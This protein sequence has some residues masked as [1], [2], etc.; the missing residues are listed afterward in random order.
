[1]SRRTEIGLFV[2]LLAVLAAAVYWNFR[3]ASSVGA[4]APMAIS[5]EPLR[6]K[7]PSLHLDRLEQLRQLSYSGSH[8]NIFSA[9]PPPLPP[10]A[11]AKK[12]GGAAGGGAETAGPPVPPALQVPLKFYGMAVDPK[13][14]KKLA[15]FTSG[16]DVYIA[17]QGQTLLGR[18]RLLSIGNDTVE[19][20]ESTSG[21]RATLTMTP[22]VTP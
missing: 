22:P 17:G 9:T 2:V 6:V 13:T 16:D 7:N 5:V 3:P 8:R 14:G 1:M 12:T 18:F 19:I 11:A 21:R 10:A 15:F 4:D 20:E